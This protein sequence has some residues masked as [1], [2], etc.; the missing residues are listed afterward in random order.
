MKTQYR[1]RTQYKE[2]EG[3]MTPTVYIPEYRN[4]CT[5]FIWTRFSLYDMFNTREE[6]ESAIRA[7]RGGL[8]TVVKYEKYE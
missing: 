3:K 2:F 6:A 7:H 5:L 8:K 1:I 4:I